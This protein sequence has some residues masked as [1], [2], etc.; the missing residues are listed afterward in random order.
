MEDL[1]EGD[2]ANN[3]DFIKE[4]SAISSGLK[5]IL[6]KYTCDGIEDLIKSCGGAGLIKFWDRKLN[7]N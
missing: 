1:A 4:Y 5:N 3:I 2:Y 7:V 6:I